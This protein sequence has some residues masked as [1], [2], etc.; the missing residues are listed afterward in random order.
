MRW[1]LDNEPALAEDAAHERGIV[2]AMH[3]G[4]KPGEVFELTFDERALHRHGERVFRLGAPERDVQA[5]F[6]TER[7]T[8][9]LEDARGIFE[10]LKRLLAE[11]GLKLPVGT[12]ASSMVDCRYSIGAA[13]GGECC[14]RAMANILSV[15]S[16]AVTRPVLPMASAAV[17]AT[18]PVPVARSST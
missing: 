11:G 5:A 13:P 15:A 2:K 6:R 4:E 8:D 17:R 7:L 10:E 14:L 12:E 1:L 9:V 16:T 3:F 18:I